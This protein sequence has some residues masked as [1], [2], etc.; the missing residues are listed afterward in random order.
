M[1]VI[2]FSDHATMKIKDE[3]NFLH[4]HC[5]ICTFIRGQFASAHHR[6]QSLRTGILRS[7][8]ALLMQFSAIVLS[9]SLK[10][11]SAY[12]IGI[13][14]LVQDIRE[15]FHQL[16]VSRQ[17]FHLFSQPTFQGFQSQSRFLLRSI[18]ELLYWIILYILSIIHTPPNCSGFIF[19]CLSSRFIPSTKSSCPICLA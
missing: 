16:E 17:G 12:Y 9:A 14:Q 7:R 3:L 15:R 1:L 19:N 8:L 4:S 5:L 10:P 11:S 2:R 13:W 18:K 6:V